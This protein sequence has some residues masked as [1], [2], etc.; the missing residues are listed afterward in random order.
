MTPETQSAAAARRGE[1]GEQPAPAIADRRAQAL[2]RRR[3]LGAFLRGASPFA[4][5]LALWYWL[6]ARGV[7]PPIFLPSPAE[8]ARVVWEMVRDGSLPAHVG[9]SLGR[10]LVGLVVSVPL[11]IGLGVVMGFRRGVARAVEPVA[12]FLNSLSGIAWLPLAITW[13]GIGWVSV[14]FILFNTIFFLVLFNTLVGV[15][16]VP[17]I[18]EHGLLTLGGRRRHIIFQVLIPGALPSIVTGIRMSMG[19]GWRAILAA[20]MISSTNGLGFLIYNA[21]NFHQTDTIIAGILIIGS[22]WLV[23]DRLLLVPIERWTVERWGL[24]W[25]PS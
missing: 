17:R 1:A 12:S 13:F 3:W 25:R 15:R 22:I 14:T 19:F 7:L 20:E 6:T 9:A 23:T 11:G 8:V 21:A 10:V 24:V 18:F 4:L 5:L 16:G 2:K